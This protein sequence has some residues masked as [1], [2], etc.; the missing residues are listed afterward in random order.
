M[1]K[2]VAVLIVALLVVTVP[3]LADTITL[4][5][6]NEEFNGL[7]SFDGSVFEV[8][9]P[10]TGGTKTLKMPPADIAQIAINKT[11]SNPGGLPPGITDVYWLK[12]PKAPK[13][14][15]RV[16][17]PPIFPTPKPRTQQ[18]NV[19]LTLAD[20]TTETGILARIGSKIEL[21]DGTHKHKRSEV[22][23]ISIQ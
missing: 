4:K 1:R 7:V 17:T 20:G 8:T 14:D 21:K 9:V 16:R 12:Q 6:T 10:S 22:R 15:A 18:V 5:E 23:L 11:T 2:K 13:M 3:A 19:E